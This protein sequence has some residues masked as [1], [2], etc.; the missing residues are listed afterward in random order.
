MLFISNKLVLWYF[1]C[2]F[3]L[4]HL[5]AWQFI[6]KKWQTGNVRK[7][8]ES[9]SSESNSLESE[10][11][12]IH[13]NKSKLIA[14]LCKFN[15][16]WIN[17]ASVAVDIS[18]IFFMSEMNFPRFFILEY[19]QCSALVAWLYNHCQNTQCARTPMPFYPIYSLW[20]FGS[21]IQ[22]FWTDTAKLIVSR[23]M[24]NV[25]FYTLICFKLGVNKIAVK[26]KTF[27]NWPVR[28]NIY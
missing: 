4:G 23:T 2:Y 5:F 15:S 10:A 7:Q 3:L 12:D 8:L 19:I 18:A 27:W 28:R 13:P 25:C 22:I 20:S 24:Q 11:L 17:R 14:L 1:L 9:G 16:L 21:K 26:E 6:L